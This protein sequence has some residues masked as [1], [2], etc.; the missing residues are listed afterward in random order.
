MKK[1]KVLSTL[2]WLMLVLKVGIFGGL[3]YIEKLS[4][5]KAGV[6]HH[7]RFR[8]TQLVRQYFTEMNTM[9]IL[10]IGAVI[11]IGALYLYFKY[12][13]KHTRLTTLVSLSPA[14]WSV[15]MI[16]ALYLPFFKELRAYPYFVLG[17]I[18]ALILSLIPRLYLWR[19]F[20]K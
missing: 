15:V 12:G 13:K 1:E 11:I 3:S 20:C 5:Q 8:K 19:N 2:F 14:L 6:N 18:I 9:I 7:L 4:Y 16:S 10:I 17:M